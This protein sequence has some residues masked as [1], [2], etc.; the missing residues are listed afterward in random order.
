MASYDA[1]LKKRMKYEKT[2]TKKGVKGKERNKAQGKRTGEHWGLKRWN[3]FKV[4]RRDKY[5][6]LNVLKEDLI[7]ILENIFRGKG[8]K[9]F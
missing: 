2:K 9:F 4:V 7:V 8:K 1:G 6:M 3:K 5:A